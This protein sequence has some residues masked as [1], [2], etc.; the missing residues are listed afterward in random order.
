MKDQYGWS[1]T[2]A[3]AHNLYDLERTPQF[4]VIKREL[5][6]KEGKARK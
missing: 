2:G 3:R 6:G 5:R 4:R 1:E